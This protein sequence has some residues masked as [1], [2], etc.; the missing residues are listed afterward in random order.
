MT[1]NVEQPQTSSDDGVHAVTADVLIAR[2]ADDQRAGRDISKDLRALQVIAG[3]QG[4]ELFDQ[5]ARA[6]HP[7]PAKVQIECLEGHE[8]VKL[9]GGTL[10]GE[11]FC[12]RRPRAD[13][14]IH[15]QNLDGTVRW[16]QRYRCVGHETVED[17]E[18]GTIQVM[19]LQEFAAETQDSQR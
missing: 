18:Y 9:R 3:Q 17:P 1:A 12:E 10:D 5:L 8:R 4:R 15:S 2:I 6:G 19:S 11:Y 7:H 14:W 13:I 16:K